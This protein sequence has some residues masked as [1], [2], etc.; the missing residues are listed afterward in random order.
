ML[1]G[2]DNHEEITIDIKKVANDALA[3]SGFHYSGREGQIACSVG[4]KV[5]I[6]GGVEQGQGEEPKE[7]N[8]IIVFDLGKFCLFSYIIF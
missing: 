7:T 8:D 1:N 5:Y 4:N 3:A 6:F 2:T